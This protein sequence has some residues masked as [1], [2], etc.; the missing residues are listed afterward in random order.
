MGTK[1]EIPNEPEVWECVLCE[2]RIDLFDQGEK[3]C[4]QII[5]A[6]GEFWIKKAGIDIADRNQLKGGMGREENV[7]GNPIGRFPLPFG[8]RGTNKFS[9]V[10]TPI[11][12]GDGRYVACVS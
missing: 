7:R 10:G 2:E 3:R 12:E 11:S 1:A 8:I 5:I 9:K 6:V 4:V